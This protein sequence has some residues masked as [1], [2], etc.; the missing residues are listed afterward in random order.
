[1]YFYMYVY[2]YLRICKYCRVLC[3]SLRFVFLA[4]QLAGSKVYRATYYKRIDNCNWYKIERVQ[5]VD[6]Y[7]AILQK[8][9]LAIERRGGVS[10]RN[11][12]I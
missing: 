12:I 5:T 11:L 2:M 7:P 6:P 3:C 10:I 1:M 4:R 8:R 9:R